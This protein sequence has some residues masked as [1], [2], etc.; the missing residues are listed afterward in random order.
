MWKKDILITGRTKDALLPTT[1][2]EVV[3]HATTVDVIY[4]RGIVSTAIADRRPFE[5]SNMVFTKFIG[6]IIK[7]RTNKASRPFLSDYLTACIDSNSIAVRWKGSGRI[8]WYSRLQSPLLANTLMM[9]LSS[10][11]VLVIAAKFNLKNELQHLRRDG[12][13]F[14][15]C[16]PIRLIA[17]TAIGGLEGQLFGLEHHGGLKRNG[18]IEIRHVVESASMEGRKR[19][20]VS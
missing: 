11:N 12:V 19:L 9:A 8:Q 5:D 4:D 14:D 7:Q 16:D 18:E 6:S 15:Y 1:V 2:C 3:L 10:A 13:V 17:T 20:G